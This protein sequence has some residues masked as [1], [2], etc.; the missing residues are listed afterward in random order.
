MG[1]ISKQ[2][3]D[4]LIAVNLCSRQLKVFKK[5]LFFFGI[6]LLHSSLLFSKTVKYENSYS[7]QNVYSF[8]Q[9]L[10]RNN[11]FYRANV[12]IDRFLSYYPENQ[13]CYRMKYTKIYLL[14]RSGR[15]SDIVNLNKRYFIEEE[16]G[17]LAYY[18]I[19]KF[20]SLM[21]LDKAGSEILFDGEEYSDKD[22]VKAVMNRKLF[23][24][25][26]GDG[27]THV[28]SKT[29]KEQ[30]DFINK[31]RVK[32]ESERI[33]PELAA[34]FGIVP[35]LGYCYSGHKGTG[36]VAF[37]TIGLGSLITYKS[38]QNGSASL[39]LISGLV[40][41]LFYGGSIIGSYLEAD[42]YNNNQKERITSLLAEELGMDKDRE[43]L[44]MKFGIG[45]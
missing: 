29:V 41:S 5:N 11:E 43:T 27:K 37:I 16:N 44:F 31:Y 2:E 13:L 35:G 15:Y 40:T 1:K 25:I 21:K 14:Y 23:Y 19:F 42:K 18:N 7:E 24:R 22:I 28:S 4:N 8:T 34:I 10:I 36:A 39:S 32:Y 20:D 26:I 33:S 45:I 38:Y 3:I 30:D 12:E 17:F 6:I 9:F